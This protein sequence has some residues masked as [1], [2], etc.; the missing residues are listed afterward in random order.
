MEA[1]PIR[2]S[3]WQAVASN[4]GQ[5]VTNGQAPNQTPRCNA[6]LLARARGCLHSLAGGLGRGCVQCGEYRRE[7]LERQRL[8]SSWAASLPRPVPWGSLSL[9]L[10]QETPPS[11]T[12]PRPADNRLAPLTQPCA[13]WPTL[14]PKP[15]FSGD[16][17]WL[18][19]QLCHAHIPKIFAEYPLCGGHRAT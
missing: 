10:I 4:R 15:H 11:P 1:Q 5:A 7:C 14:S 8:R 19:H 13:A 16:Q 12:P 2:S 18:C 3:L 6:H 9:V 17:A